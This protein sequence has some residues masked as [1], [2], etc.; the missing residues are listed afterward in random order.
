[1]FHDGESSSAD[2]KRCKGIIADQSQVSKAAQ[3]G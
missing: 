3:G 2:K 1:M